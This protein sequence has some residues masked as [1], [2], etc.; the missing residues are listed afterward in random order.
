MAAAFLA[1]NDVYGNVF[2]VTPAEA[3]ELDGHCAARG[4]KFS[5]HVTRRHLSGN[6]SGL[7]GAAQLR[8][9]LMQCETY[10]GCAA[11]LEDARA[12]LAA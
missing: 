1:M 2:Q 7:T 11:I 4:E 3:R 6:Q 12:R 5:C 8:R 9:A 10:D